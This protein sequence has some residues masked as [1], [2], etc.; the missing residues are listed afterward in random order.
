MAER[1]DNAVKTIYAVGTALAFFFITLMIML[2][3]NSAA[4]LPTDPLQAIIVWLI[5]III[6]ILTFFV[7]RGIPNNELFN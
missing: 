3:L 5:P 2:A 6:P 7:I 4:V 1:V